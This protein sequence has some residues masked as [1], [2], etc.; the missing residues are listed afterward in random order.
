MTISR[1]KNDTKRP[2]G[3]APERREIEAA[4]SAFR[5]VTGLEICI[6]LLRYR[7]APTSL[8]TVAARHGLHASAFCMEVKRTRTELCKACDLRAVPER[9]ERERTVFSHVCHAGA[10]E[11]IIPLFVEEALAGLVYVGQFRTSDGQPAGLPC[12][13]EEKVGEVMALSRL[14]AA[15]LGE[16]LRAARFETDG[17]RGKRGETIRSFLTKNLSANPS[18]SD[19]AGHLGLSATR[20]AHVVREATGSSFLE[21][22]DALRMERARGLLEG[23][24]HKITYIATECGFAYPQYFHRFF[25]KHARVT[26]L[27]YRNRRRAEA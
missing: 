24:Y 19:L 11:V 16:R 25:R 9:C 17:S 20:T 21:L 10:G 26:P 4:L 1:K 2:V 6:K 13:S 5:A 15:Y 22:R 23:T 14:L 3:D 8:D 12:L 27:A 18:L 7:A